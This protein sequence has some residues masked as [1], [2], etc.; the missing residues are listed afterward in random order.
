MLI[1]PTH[2]DDA[3]AIWRIIHPVIRDGA[4]YALDRSMSECDALNYWIGRDRES[5]VAED[6]GQIVGTYY[7]RANQ[8]GGGA[9]ICNCG[10]ITSSEATGRG[11]A[12][13]MC[14]HSLDHA[15][16]RGYRGMQFNFVLAT[17]TRAIA[18]WQ[19]LGFEIVGRIPAAFSHPNAGYV[20][21]FVMFRS[22]I[23][24]PRRL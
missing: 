18:L 7:L 8:A 12:R 15:R 22:L 19:S 6:N 21:A 24:D 1:R 13:A 4:T 17:N 16:Q 3:P 9:H 11:V 23:D 14:Q 20:D 10:Y 5:F 2:P